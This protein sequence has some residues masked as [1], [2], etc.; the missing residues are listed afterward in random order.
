MKNNQ[1]F[2]SVA[3]KW[4][5]FVL[6]SA[7]V[8][9]MI[10]FPSWQNLCGCI[11]ALICWTIFRT[12]FFTKDLVLE[13]P[14]AFVMFLS[15]LLYRYLPLVATLVEGK[16][17]TYGFEMAYQ[18]FFFETLLFVVS[19][20]AFYLACNKKKRQNNLMQRLLYSTGFFNNN[21][22][23]LWGLGV[24]GV[25]VH[26]YVYAQGYGLIEYGD[27]LGKF[28]SGVIFLM[29]APLCL[30]FPTLLNINVSAG[31][32]RVVWS[33]IVFICLLN[34][35]TN[36]RMAILT[37]IITTL[38]LFLLHIIKNNIDITRLI[39]P[40]KTVLLVILFVFGLN[41][42]SDISLVMLANR[43]IR[44]DVKWTG[45]INETIETYQDKRVMQMLRSEWAKENTVV[46]S[47]VIGW[48]E[49]YIDNFMLN[50]YGN[51]RITD[52]TLYYA[53]KT[54][55]M[56]KAM[57]ND[58]IDQLWKL[59]PT[60]LITI[61][62]LPVD[63]EK[64]EYSRGDLLARE[65]LGGYRVTSHAG[66]GVATFG[67]WYFPIQFVIFFFMF[68]LLDCFVFYFNSGVKYTALGLMNIFIFLG[69]FRNATGCLG[70]L[71]FCIRGFWQLCFVYILFFTLIKKILFIKFKN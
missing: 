68:K 56:N 12:F 23:I 18:T 54:G 62:N 46:N 55:W 4:M 63:K 40:A 50:R 52:E 42:L 43:G 36:S 69:Q 33:Y 67:Y 21:A 19:A 1:D 48:E 15:M 28:M 26:L 11:M 30:L 66:D 65:S 39:S 51:M 34:F 16:P 13:H 44:G 10:F 61:L 38:L 41:F 5:G 17:I 57:Q 47:Y 20:F 35:A 64:L 70:D 3:K 29:Y 7:V 22:T 31:S 9:E 27:V 8:L 2:V 58:F 32:R 59:L 71:S 14:F 37:P 24:I 45:L 49:T 6:Y 60:P 53:N 25:A